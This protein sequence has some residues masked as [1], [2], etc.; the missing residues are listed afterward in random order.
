MDDSIKNANRAITTISDEILTI[1]EDIE[2]IIH[3]TDGLS[4]TE[5][6]LKAKAT[7]NICQY[8][9]KELQEIRSE[10]P[11]NSEATY[12]KHIIQEHGVL[13]QNQINILEPL[14]RAYE[15]NIAKQREIIASVTAYEKELAS[16]MFVKRNRR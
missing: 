7:H 6:L 13:I 3:D 10:L 12:I 15:E 5:V 2:H 16:E 9:Q 14:I 11:D 8:L 1:Q 4:M